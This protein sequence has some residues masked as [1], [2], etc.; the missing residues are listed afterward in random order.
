MNEWNDIL[1]FFN[2]FLSF[3]CRQS[4][5]D[6][7]SQQPKDQGTKFIQG[8]IR[9]EDV[10][11]SYPSRPELNVLSGT[12]LSA[13]PGNKIAIVGHSGSGKSTIAQLLQR[14]YDPIKGNIYTVHSKN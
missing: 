6:P 14:F 2:N 11:F 4:N 10:S 9:F 12:N 13:E 8:R 5:I 7:L 1:S 3:R